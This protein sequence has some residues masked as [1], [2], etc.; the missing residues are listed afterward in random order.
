MTQTDVAGVFGQTKSNVSHYETG[1]QELPPACA[2]FLIEAARGRGREITFD[3][4]Y[5]VPKLGA[6][7]TPQSQSLSGTAQRLP[8]TPPTTQQEAA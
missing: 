8:D 2:R 1:K 7:D 4:I 3:E 5:D 6:D